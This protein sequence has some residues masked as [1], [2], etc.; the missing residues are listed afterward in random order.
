MVL[1]AICALLMAGIVTVQVAVLRLNGD[2]GRLQQQLEDLKSGNASLANASAG[3][4]RITAARARALEL[5]MVQLPIDD[6]KYLPR[7]R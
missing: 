5:R 2:R 1:I 4:D 6:T 3:G 7:A